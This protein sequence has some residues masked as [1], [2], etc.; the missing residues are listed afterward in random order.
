MFA[1]WYLL[2]ND[3]ETGP[4]SRTPSI[5]QLPFPIIATKLSKLY[6]QSVDKSL[7]HYMFIKYT[8]IRATWPSLKIQNVT[9]TR[10]SS[11]H[12]DKNAIQKRGIS[13]TKITNVL[14]SNELSK[15]HRNS[16]PLRT[17]SANWN[18]TELPDITDNLYHLASKRRFT[19]ATTQFHPISN[20]DLA[21]ASNVA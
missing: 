10:K 13:T 18:T 16:H 15:F 20:T 19:L 17:Y 2:P 5:H 21:A 1:N 11:R 3:N 6:N 7:R 8:C 9:V 12:I 4:L 14:R